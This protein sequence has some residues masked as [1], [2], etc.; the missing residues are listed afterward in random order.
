MRR[1]NSLTDDKKLLSNRKWFDGMSTF[2]LSEKQFF[3]S[4]SN[5]KKLSHM[6]ISSI[7]ENK[8]S[9]RKRNKMFNCSRVK[10]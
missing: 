4:F 7:I 5:D 9:H 6:D 10:T 1:K 3:G 8:S 2:Y